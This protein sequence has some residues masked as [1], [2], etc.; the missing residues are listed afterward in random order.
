M[1]RYKISAVELKITLQPLPT[2][3]HSFSRISMSHSI[4]QFVIRILLFSEIL[5]Y[6]SIEY[7][8]LLVQVQFYCVIQRTQ[9]ASQP[10]V[11]QISTDLFI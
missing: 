8:F 5:I 7:S 10:Q 2:F 1:M 4:Q 9:P 11:S 6:D 3:T